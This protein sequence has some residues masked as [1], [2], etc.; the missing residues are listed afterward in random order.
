MESSILQV[1]LRPELLKLLLFDIQDGN[2]YA[3]IENNTD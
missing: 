2:Q 1:N 3:G